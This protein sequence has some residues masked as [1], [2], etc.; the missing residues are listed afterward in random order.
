[1]RVPPEWGKGAKENNR[2]DHS[3]GV[4]KNATLLRTLTIVLLG[5]TVETTFPA[6]EPGPLNPVGP[7]AVGLFKTLDQVEPRTPI[8]SLPFTINQPGSYYLTGNLTGAP[9]ANG[10]NISASDVTLDLGGFA[11][12]GSGGAGGDG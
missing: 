11:L 8:S 10:I 2:T 6:A 1:M 5:T 3:I 12:I 9:G 4:M 7:P